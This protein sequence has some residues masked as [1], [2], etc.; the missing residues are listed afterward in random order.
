MVEDAIIADRLIY[1]YGQTKAVDR[2]SFNVGDIGTNNQSDQ[3]QDKANN[4]VEQGGHNNASSEILL[5]LDG[6]NPLPELR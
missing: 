1:H 3:Q 4:N 6:I 2:I 5:V